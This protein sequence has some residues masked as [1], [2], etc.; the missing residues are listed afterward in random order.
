MRSPSVPLVS[1]RRPLAT[2]VTAVTSITPIIS[3][4]AVTA[5]RP[6]WRIALRRASPPAEPPI[7]AAGRPS[8]PAAARTRRDGRRSLRALGSASR[9]AATGAIFVARRAGRMPAASVTSVP[10]SSATIDRARLEHR[11]RLGQLEVERAEHGVEPGR[12]AEAGGEADQRRADPERERLDHHRAEHLPARR[13][14]HPQH[15][16]LARALGDG[17]RE[18]VEDRER[19]HEDRHAAEHQQ[20]GLDDAD[21]LLQP[22]EGEAVLRGGASGPDGRA[23]RGGDGA[24]HVGAARA[25]LARDEDRSRSGPACGTASGRWRGRRRRSSPVPSDLTVP[26]RGEADHAEGRRRSARV[27][28]HRRAELVV[29]ALGRGDVD[30]DLARAGRPAAVLEAER[31]SSFSAPGVRASKPV[32]K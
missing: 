32:P 3:A 13:A 12:D 22:V 9:S 17:D 28:L 21:E 31:R 29:L 23:D 30:D 16:E 18:R 26:K 8:S 24:A 15:R 6:G 27:D 2:T 5:V 10:T 20:H 7:A 4:L 1:W 14:D 11:A 19:A 25:G